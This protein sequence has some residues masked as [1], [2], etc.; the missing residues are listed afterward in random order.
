VTSSTQTVVPQGGGVGTVFRSIAPE[1]KRDGSWYSSV[2][3]ALGRSME[4]L[5]SKQDDKGFWCAELQGDSILESEYILMKFILAQ[6]DDPDLVRIANYLRKIQMP[7]GGWNMY[8]GGKAD[9]SGTVKGYFALKLMGDDADAPH[10]VRARAVIHALGGAEKCNTFTKFFFA[11]LGQI[12][13]DAC[14]SIPPEVVLLPKWCYFNLYHVSAWT[15]TMI[16]P[17]GIVTTLKYMRQIPA[18]K[19][20]AE[21]YLDEGAKNRLADPIKGLPRNWREVFLRIDQL[22][23]WYN[24]APVEALRAKAMQEA[25]K[26]LLAHL[27]GSEGL[28]AIFPP[29]V[30]ILIVL[31]ALG[32]PEDHP[33]VVEGHRQLRDF[34][35]REG[36]EIRLQPCVSPVWDTGIALH[37][38][39]EG[40]LPPESQ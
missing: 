34:Y 7:G 17:L 18:Q 2:E 16:L 22:L 14:P 27:D 8:P 1:E 20:I 32:Y 19:G 35:I 37:A 9:L 28:G 6:E 40:G 29:M 4:C 12:S 11:C 23:K 26:W 3:G 15:R 21:L 39:A 24:G 31:R 13:F 36:D 25:E 38:L 30:Y 33:R 10:M 5:L